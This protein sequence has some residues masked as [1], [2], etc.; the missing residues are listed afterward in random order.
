[1]QLACII[2]IS[3][4][5]QD[6][7][8]AKVT[9]HVHNCMRESMSTADGRQTRVTL[10]DAVQ[11]TTGAPPDAAVQQFHVIHASDMLH[12]ACTCSNNTKRHGIL[13]VG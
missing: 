5:S 10:S 13:S 11:D 4:V 6:A 2:A 7:A 9:Y 3:A 1:M 12:F 8:V